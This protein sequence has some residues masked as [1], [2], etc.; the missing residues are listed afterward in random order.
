[1]RIAAR[2]MQ[3]TRVSEMPTSLS[4]LN[5]RVIGLSNG[6]DKSRLVREHMRFCHKPIMTSLSLPTGTPQAWSTAL[7]TTYRRSRWLP[8]PSSSAQAATMRMPWRLAQLQDPRFSNE[9]SLTSEYSNKA[10]QRSFRLS[11][12]ARSLTDWCS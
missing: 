6:R 8:P 10:R 1:M 12:Y 2:P 5:E 3:S 4:E 7:S 9:R 11:V